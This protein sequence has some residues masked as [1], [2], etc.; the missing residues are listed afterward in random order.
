MLSSVWLSQSW[1]YHIMYLCKSSHQCRISRQLLCL[2]WLAVAASQTA[3]GRKAQ[4]CCRFVE[5]GGCWKEQAGPHCFGWTRLQLLKVWTESSVMKK[6]GCKN[7]N[8]NWILVKDACDHGSLCELNLVWWRIMHVTN[9]S[10]IEQVWIESMCG[11]GI[12]VAMLKN[13]NWNR[14]THV[15]MGAC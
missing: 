12:H 1:S 4:H 8:V 5:S 7:E 15:T 11:E 3:P 10:L 6:D 14:G 13:V 2:W 9:R